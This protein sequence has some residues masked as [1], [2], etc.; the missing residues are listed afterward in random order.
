M[1][2]DACEGLWACV[3]YLFFSVSRCRRLL[4]PAAAGMGCA[5]E[6]GRDA[7]QPEQEAAG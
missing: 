5:A 7:R 6:T 1:A 2:L 3:W 4:G